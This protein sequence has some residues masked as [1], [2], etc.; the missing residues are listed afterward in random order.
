MSEHNWNDELTDTD[1]RE[2][3]HHHAE[4]GAVLGGIAGAAAGV[5]AGSAIG[6][7]GAIFG[8]VVGG[9]VGAAAGDATTDSWGVVDE[10]STNDDKPL[11]GEEVIN[12][13]ESPQRNV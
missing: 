8:A 12:T 7:P 9:L 6:P 13:E 3:S 11:G 10:L 4:Q 2:N 5:A 1:I